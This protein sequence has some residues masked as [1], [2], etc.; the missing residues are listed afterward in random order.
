MSPA[1]PRSL[2]V[3]GF[4]LW[5]AVLLPLSYWMSRDADTRREY[6]LLAVDLCRS[7][8]ALR[9]VAIRRFASRN[10]HLPESLADCAEDF[11]SL[12]D[13]AERAWIGGCMI[14]EPW[15]RYESV[16]LEADGLPPVPVPEV[17]RDLFG[18]PIIY[19]TGRGPGPDPDDTWV[20]SDD[21]LPADVQEFLGGRGGEP[22]PSPAPFAL[23]SLVLRDRVARRASGQVKMVLAWVMF[24]GAL[25]ALIVATVFVVK[26]W[27]GRTSGPK[28]RAAIASTAIISALAGFAGFLGT[29]ATCYGAVTFRSRDLSR[30]ERQSILDDAVARGEVDPTV[31]DRARG[32]L[33]NLPR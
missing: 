13:W 16:I 5:L 24:I 2:V 21:P 12:P 27:A 20:R 6:D 15:G 30:E 9:A 23:S 31:A 7:D 33:E 17:S 32:S 18:L 10:G 11:P 8:L 26:R 1:V 19:L 28:G 3:L 29:Q 4:G 25:V 22:A 14:T